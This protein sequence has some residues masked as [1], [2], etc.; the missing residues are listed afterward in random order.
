MP[1]VTVGKENS[2]DINLYYNDWGSGHPVVVQDRQG[3]HT[4][5]LSGR[6]TRHVHNAQA[7]GQ[8]GIARV[9]QGVSK[10]HTE[11]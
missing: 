1:Y 2:G 8:R 3:P 7:T 10:S 6:A 11:K 9:L 4:E 5:N